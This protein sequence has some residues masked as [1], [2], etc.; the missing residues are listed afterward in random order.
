MLSVSEVASA[1][2]RVEGVT[3]WTGLSTLSAP[4]LR[5]WLAAFGVRH[6]ET[7]EPSDLE[8]DPQLVVVAEWRDPAQLLRDHV[9]NAVTDALLE[10]AERGDALGY[11]WYELP[12]ARVMKG[13]SWVLERFGKIGP[14]P[15]G[16]SPSAA[17]RNSVYTA[18]HRELAARVRA[19]AERI[20][21]QQGYFPPY[22]VLLDLA[23]KAVGAG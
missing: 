9:D 5:R 17:L 20:A 21:G 2:Y 18:R 4:G 13:Y 10:G 14:V 11:P 8:Y 1:A 12:L 3:L 15:E 22:W 7:Q 23:R 19:E 16:M 6:F